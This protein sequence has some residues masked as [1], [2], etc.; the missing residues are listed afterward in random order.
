MVLPL[1]QVDGTLVQHAVTV[2]PGTA[3]AS[4]RYED[5]YRFKVPQLRRI[6]QLG[7]YFHDNSAPTLEAVIDH[8]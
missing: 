2:D 7:P 3:S 8:F 6:S 4:G 5:L 1:A